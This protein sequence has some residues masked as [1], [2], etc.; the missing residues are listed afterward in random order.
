MIFTKK[1]KDFIEQHNHISIQ[2]MIYFLED[3]EGL[4]KVYLT[5]EEIENLHAY[6]LNMLDRED[7]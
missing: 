6:Y 4:A 3:G 5:Q 7:N 1:E 2:D